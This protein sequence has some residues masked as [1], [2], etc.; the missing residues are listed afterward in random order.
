MAEQLEA[1]RLRRWDEAQHA[2]ALERERR[3]TLQ[4]GMRDLLR[5]AE[6]ALLPDSTPTAVASVSEPAPFD[7]ATELA[8]A[9]GEGSD[10]EILPVANMLRALGPKCGGTV[11][12]PAPAH[13]PQR[14]PKKK[15]A[16]SAAGRR[17]T[18]SAT[19]T[20]RQRAAVAAVDPS[21]PRNSQRRCSLPADDDTAVVADSTTISQN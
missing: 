18:P 13:A 5:K 15:A 10:P 21:L 14:A 6:Q 17:S 3:A 8:A 19:K 2:L 11:A 1:E 16:K 12:A 4:D 7:P 9:S 20:T